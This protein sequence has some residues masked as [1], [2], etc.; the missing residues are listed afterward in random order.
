MDEML[1]ALGTYIKLAVDIERSI[2]AGGKA[3]M[4]IVSQL[5]WKMAVFKKIFGAQIGIQRRNRLFMN[6]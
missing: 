1:Q 3:P 6:R 2:L 5:C 4:P